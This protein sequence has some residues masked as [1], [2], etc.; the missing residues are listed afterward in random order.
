MLNTRAKFVQILRVGSIVV[1]TITNS[2]W[3]LVK[4]KVNSAQNLS[5]QILH[6]TTSSRHIAS[7]GVRKVNISRSVYMGPVLMYRSVS[8]MLIYT[9]NIVR[10]WP[11]HSL[12]P[13]TGFHTARYCGRRLHL[14][15]A[16]DLFRG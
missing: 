6:T 16:T 11:S 12:E 10:L 4:I 3:T 8:D 14:H 2:H 9:V 1:P 7:G 5:A 13:K 15:F